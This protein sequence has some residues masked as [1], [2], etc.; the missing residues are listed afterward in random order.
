MT[1]IQVK[2]VISSLCHILEAFNFS[3]V[4]AEDLRLAKF[5]KPEIV[6]I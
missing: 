3:T 4:T 5:N 2:Q 1:Q 6:I